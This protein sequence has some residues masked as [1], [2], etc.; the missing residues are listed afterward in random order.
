MESS[1]KEPVPHRPSSGLPIWL[2][3]AL[4]GLVVLVFFGFIRGFGPGRAG[5]ALF[6][7][8]DSWNGE[9]QYQHGFLFPLIILGLIVWQWKRLREE[10]TDV[11]APSAAWIGWGCI[12]LG[13]LLYVAAHRTIQPRIAIGALPFILWGASLL[14][15]GWRTALLLWFPFFFI[16]L[17]VPVPAFQQATTQLQI[18]ST[19]L[20]QH[21]SALF[22]VETVV[23]G[24]QIHSISNKWAPLEIDE[25]CGGIRS[26]M[27]LLMVSA[28]WAY[29]AK[30]SLWKK[31]VLF[32]A[33]FP[34][35]IIGN[36]LRLVSIFVIA[37]YGD[38]K[39]AGG[40]W[41]DWSGL[42]LFYPISLVL[43]LITHSLLEG[44]LP[45][46]GRRQAR[47]VITR[48]PMQAT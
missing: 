15:W 38:P 14:F 8:G 9:T 19:E 30:M 3:P 6:W 24:T 31:L 44:G 23:R 40:T 22:K 46:K 4:C 21:G 28:T 17:A 36:M 48:R 25:G 18:L 34:L 43:L 1:P 7:L 12:V 39:F 2:G 32:L 20:A 5:S 29:I 47:R 45:W 16:W 27:A 13:S 35:A 41:H 26:L 42:L 11:Q 10:A 37:E 33:A